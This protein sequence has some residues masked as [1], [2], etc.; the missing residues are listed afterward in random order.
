MDFVTEWR[1]IH[2]VTIREE[3]SERT[4]LAKMF[5]DYEIRH[6]LA[7]LGFAL[8]VAAPVAWGLSGEWVAAVFSASIGMLMISVAALLVPELQTESIAHEFGEDR[9]NS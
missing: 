1:P 4:G 2:V 9:R 7:I 8:I 3:R 5:S 6:W